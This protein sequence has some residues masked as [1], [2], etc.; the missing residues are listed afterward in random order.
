MTT[1]NPEPSPELFVKI[2]KRIRKEERILFFKRIAIF[3]VM[4]MASGVAFV[5]AIKMLVQESQTSGFIY[6]V[7]LA[8]SD[9]AV[10]KTY[11]Q[12]F[13]LTLL[14]TLPALSVAFCLAVLLTFLQ[15]I[16][17]LSK[18]IKSVYN[19]KWT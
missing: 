3:S 5:P 18:N 7:S 16:K 14:E 12:S 4:L 6:F 2:M 19:I 8:F 10:V 11:W 17:S 1:I 15:S 13:S 9:F